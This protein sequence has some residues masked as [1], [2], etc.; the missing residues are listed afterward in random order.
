MYCVAPPVILV[1]NHSSGDTTSTAT[2]D[3]GCI[4]SSL[5]KKVTQ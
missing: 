5:V 1:I 4:K 3:V 2:F